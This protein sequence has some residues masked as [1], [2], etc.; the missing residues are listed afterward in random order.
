MHEETGVTMCERAALVSTLRA[1]GDIALKYFTQ[2][3]VS[4]KEDQTIVTQAD[5]EVQEFVVDAL[6]RHYPDDGIVAEEQGFH[7]SSRSGRHWTVDPID[8]TV[9]FVAGLTSW[10]IAVGLIDRGHPA[11]G[12]IYLPTSRELF[13]SDV[14]HGVFRNGRPAQLK[15]SRLLGKGAILFGPTM[16]HQ[17]FRL[18]PAFP[19]RVFCMGSSTVQLACLATG[20]AD[21]ILMGLEQVWDLA[22]G[23]AMLKAAGGTMCYL[24]G[25]AVDLESYLDGSWSREP[26]IGGHADIIPQVIAHLE[27]W[28]PYEVF[29][30]GG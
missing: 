17:N 19:G 6:V 8:G 15:D 1:A 11:A 27:Y 30:H 3:T 23:L 14:A 10:S 22:P 26:M 28:L 12:F 29:G 21:A 4:V 20:G 24:D 2:S 13:C 25:T 18:D 9:P 5:F 7:K 16:M